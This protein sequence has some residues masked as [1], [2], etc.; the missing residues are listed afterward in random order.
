MEDEG[1]QPWFPA[2]MIPSPLPRLQEGQPR[3]EQ[4]LLRPRGHQG[5][6]LDPGLPKPRPCPLPQRLVALGRVVLGEPLEGQPQEELLKIT[7]DRIHD[8]KELSGIQTDDF[9]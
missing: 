4:G 2:T 9:R 8:D 3:E 1:P 5:Q 7:F 6:P